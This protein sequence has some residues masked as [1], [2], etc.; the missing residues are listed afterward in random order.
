LSTGQSDGGAQCTVIELAWDPARAASNLARHGVAFAQ[1]TTVFADGLALRVFD[2]AH[3]EFEQ[4]W[5]TL[6][7]ASNGR[8]LAVSHTRTRRPLRPAHE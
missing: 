6:A 2:T 1:A 4:R 7:M 8:A 3:G 5:F